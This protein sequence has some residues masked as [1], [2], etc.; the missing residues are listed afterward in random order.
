MTFP[1][2]PSTAEAS[3]QTMN[4]AKGFAQAG[5]RYPLFGIMLGGRARRAGE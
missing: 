1:D 5:N 4:R 3:S 2:L